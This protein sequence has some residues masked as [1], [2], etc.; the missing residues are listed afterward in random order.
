MSY[1]FVHD[2]ANRRLKVGEFSFLFEVVE[3]VG[4]AWRGVLKLD[5]EAAVAALRS[6]VASTGIREI[7][8]AEYNDYLKKKTA[9]TPRLPSQR[10]KTPQFHEG[11]RAAAVVVTVPGSQPTKAV[12]KPAETKAALETVLKVGKAPFVDPLEVK[13]A[14]KKKQKAAANP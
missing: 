1:Y 7:T 4:G 13:P 10:I 11:E 3:G 6:I 2:N 12:G 14:S 5:D 9:S 8:E